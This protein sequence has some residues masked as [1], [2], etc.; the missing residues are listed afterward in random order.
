MSAFSSVLLGEQ[1]LLIQCGEALLAR[2]HRVETVITRDARIAAWAGTRGIR[3]ADDFEMLRDRAFTPAFDY[4]FSITN[5]RIV[6]RWLLDQASRLAINFHDGPLPRHAGLNAPVWALLEGDS[7]YGITWHVMEEGTDRGAVLVQQHF[8][9]A[10]DETAFSLNAQCYAAGLEAF[11]ELLA[12]L[13]QG[14]VAPRPQE[15]AQRTLHAARDRPPAAATLDFRESAESLARLVRALDFGRYPNP[16]LLPRIRLGAHCLLVRAAEVVP[17]DRG[18]AAGEVQHL[19]D[20]AV[21]IRCAVDALRVTRL[22]DLEGEPTAAG[23][24]FAVRGLVVGDRLPDL[25]VVDR[26]VIDEL[27]ARI[28]PHEAFWIARLASIEPAE[29]PFP[30]TGD[31]A[32]SLSRELPLELPADDCIAVVIAALARLANRESLTVGYVPGSVPAGALANEYVERV[33][34]LSVAVDD[35]LGFDALRDRVSAV[36]GDLARH[37][38]HLTDLVART[39]ELHGLPVAARLPVRIVRD[40]GASGGAAA[41]VVIPPAGGRITL[42]LRGPAAVTAHADRFLHAVRAIAHAAR[43]SPVMPLH[44]IG[45]LEEADLRQLAEWTAEPPLIDEP[46]PTRELVHA[47]IAAQAARTPDRVACIAGAEQRTYA[48]I[49]AAAN[50]LAHRLGALGV[51]RGDRVGVLL[52][53]SVDLPAALLGILKAGAAYVPLDPT[54]P[55]ERLALMGADARL[56]AIVTERAHAGRVPAPQVV[57][58]DDPADAWR[59]ESCTAP[60][61]AVDASDLAYVIFTSGSTGRPKGVMVEHRNVAH[62]LVAMDGQVEGPPGVWLAVTS[63]SF[64]ISVLELLWT[65]ARGFTVVVYSTERAMAPARPVEF[66]FFYWNVAR[67]DSIHDADKYRLLLESARFAD[68]HGFNAVWTPERHFA[69]FGGLYPNPSVTSAALATITQRVGLRAGSCVV[70]LHSPIRIA[71]EWA[72]VDNLSNGRVGVSIAAGWAAPDFAI[73]PQAFAE[74]KREMFEGADLVRRLWRGETLTFPGPNGDVAVRTLPRPVQPELPL[75]VTAATNV[76]TFIEAGR[77]GANLLTHLLGQSVEDVAEKVRAYRDARQRAGHAGRG[78]VTLMLHT[79]IGPDR[80]AVERAVRDP[81]KAYLR[82]AVSLVK[83]AAWQFPT[84]RRL[85]A[86]QGTSLDEFFTEASPEDL[87]AL[88]EFAF[89]RYF[90]TSGLFG[91]VEDGLAMVERVNAADVDEIACLIDFGVPAELVLGHLPH[92]DALRERAQSRSTRSVPPEPIGALLARHAVTH[93]QCTPS[94]ATMLLADPQA[95][96]GL[97]QLTQLLVGG[98]ALPPP[99]ARALRECVGG[100]VTN[101][102]GPTETTVW[103]SADEVGEPVTIG[104]ALPGEVLRI[105]DRRMQPVP[106]GAIGEVVIGGEGV[107]RGYW[108]RPDL[109]AERF[110]PD[111]CGARPGARMYRTGDLGRWLDDGRIECLGRADQQVKLRGFRVELGEIEARLRALDGVREAA[112]VLR[113]DVPG[114]Q[115]LLAYVVGTPHTVLDAVALRE[116][117]LDGL[118]EFMLPSQVVVLPALPRTPNGKLDRR[119]LPVPT[120]SAATRDGADAPVPRSD[121]ERMLAGIWQKTLG[122]DHVGTRDNFFDLGG[123]SLLVVQV[124]KELRDRVDRPVQ[125]TDLFRHTTIEA[126]ARFLTSSA[127]PD[128]GAVRGRARAEARRAAQRRGAR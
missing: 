117:L 123:H 17:G 51:G 27:V 13:E 29:W 3:C 70:P 18:R 92:L 72:V 44:A 85:S 80:A 2:G 5:L 48:E 4:L 58:L 52:D 42:E 9:I 105:L 45:L 59:D 32:A 93:L 108:D 22:T 75:W 1:S 102:Y 115:R 20:A 65:L 113:E 125:M 82:S 35:A 126:L 94:M 50:R 101:L 122:L 87:D 34:P 40:V 119:A 62:F 76:E 12:Q 8:P 88:L 53:R 109:T 95:A 11:A 37:E 31:S 107:T 81:F 118:P 96:A 56:A 26:N 124:L 68:T 100:R 84:F 61:G 116:R 43:S 55:A 19:E 104:R 30:S 83:A 28:A 79:F 114:D 33:L 36:L 90:R 66:G 7:D 91:T 86:E 39:P 103:S 110:V 73:R 121:L 71:E 16:V 25:D 24:A 97:A 47:A 112:A 120:R 15:V 49:D 54:Y 78:V 111:P 106:P 10:Q 127:E 6:P 128:A 99:L 21:T 38:S 69:A 60:A 57:V 67:D 23:A 74:A 63:M 46:A 77:I 41:T 98:E 89:E 64:D 14:R